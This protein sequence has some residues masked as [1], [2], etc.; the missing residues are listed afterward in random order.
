MAGPQSQIQSALQ[1]QTGLQTAAQGAVPSAVN[2]GNP[3]TIYNTP[4]G[5]TF[6]NT[7]PPPM[8]T[9]L[10]QWYIPQSQAPGWA[11]PAGQTVNPT[12]IMW[13]NPVFPTNGGA[14]APPPGGG[15]GGVPGIAGKP[16][17]PPN[18][19]GGGGVP[20]QQG[21]YKPVPP[22]WD[23]IL[24][25]SGV[26]VGADG[27]STWNRAQQ[28]TK[29]VESRL[30]GARDQN[31][32]WDWKQ[33]IDIVTEP[34]LGGNLWLSGS[35]KWDASNGIASL[36]QSMTGIPVGDIM[37]KLGK[38]QATQNDPADSWI[39]KLLADHWEDNAQNDVRVF[40]DTLNRYLTGYADFK[41]SSQNNA[42]SNANQNWLSNY[43]DALASAMLNGLK[44]QAAADAARKAADA[45][46]RNYTTPGGGV[47][48]PGR[49]GGGDS[50]PNDRGIY[51]SSDGCVVVDNIIDGYDFAD[52]VRVGDV[53]S[54]I[55]HGSFERKDATVTQAST[56]IRPCVRITTKHGVVLEC[57]IDAEIA[58]EEGNRIRADKL[59]GVAV[60]SMIDDKKV[61]DIVLK[62]E[63]IG[64]QAVKK[65]TAENN[66]YLAGKEKGKYL[67]HH[68]EKYFNSYGNRTTGSG[69]QGS[70]SITPNGLMWGW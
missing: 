15:S 8:T 10:G 1:Q 17:V 67:L 5:Q 3:N 34:L 70:G 58:D 7:P 51:A 40:Q 55:E 21:V 47:A 59:L 33:I 28:W 19:L 29:A 24:R 64:N 69:W 66:W 26:Q 16:A 9:A 22:N 61:D 56:V 41:V 42:N 46:G 6:T 50:G 2:N 57:S 14:G 11:P 45:K 63:K 31:G 32:N 68:N 60:P 30:G 35:K 52:D 62:I 25:K 53:M 38:W 48:T 13:P 54:V 20:T 36:I 18:V 65:I 27:T 12:P 23:D 4:W 44:G 37:N 49:P 43:S 39:E